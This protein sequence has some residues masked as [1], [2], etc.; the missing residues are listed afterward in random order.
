MSEDKRDKLKHPIQP[1][2]LDAS[3]VIRFKENKIVSFLLEKGPYD[4]NKLSMMD[5]TQ[6]D[7]EHFAQ[8]I[9]YSKSGWSGLSYVSDET[10]QR[11]ATIA[12]LRGLP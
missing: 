7:R 8:L 3:G 5:F 4:L 12:K 9:G 6:E 11:V 2:D 1:F 10:W